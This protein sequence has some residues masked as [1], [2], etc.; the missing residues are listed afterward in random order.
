MAGRRQAAQPALPKATGVLVAARAG[1]RRPQA[2]MR[3][4]RPEGQE[5]DAPGDVQCL[6]D[7]DDIPSAALDRARMYDD[8]PS[9]IDETLAGLP[10]RPASTRRAAPADRTRRA[11]RR[12]GVRRWP[13][14]AM[15]AT[16]PGHA[17]RLRLA[18][19]ADRRD[20]GPPMT[21]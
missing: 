17:R 18:P 15:A 8:V 5:T 12:T 9:V 10:A 11:G 21:P 16:H 6:R 1:V 14:E 3:P 20:V 2:R 4:P 7:T 19:G 13:S